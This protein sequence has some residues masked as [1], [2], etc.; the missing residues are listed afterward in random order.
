MQY[1][2]TCNFPGSRSATGDYVENYYLFCYVS[3]NQVDYI[4]DLS[5]IRDWAT[6]FSLEEAQ[7]ERMFMRG[8]VVS[9]TNNNNWGTVRKAGAASASIPSDIKPHR[10]TSQP[11]CLT[12]YLS[13]IGL[14]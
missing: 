5:R 13:L 6:P 8:Q 11:T 2:V 9:P 7:C 12:K 4:I 3:T 14:D 10:L 1:Y